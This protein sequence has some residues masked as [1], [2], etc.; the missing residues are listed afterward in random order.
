MSGNLKASS[1]LSERKTG[2]FLDY[3]LYYLFYSVQQNDLSQI[4]WSSPLYCRWTCRGFVVDSSLMLETL[5]LSPKNDPEFPKRCLARN[6]ASHSLL[7]LILRHPLSALLLPSQGFMFYMILSVCIFCVLII[8][9]AICWYFG[10][11]DIWNTGSISIENALI[12]IVSFFIKFNVKFDYSLQSLCWKYYFKASKIICFKLSFLI[13]KIYS[14]SK[15]SIRQF[16]R[17]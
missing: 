6:F 14:F 7:I 1:W 3:L 17:K 16:A 9:I 13:F 2:T 5:L 15:N 8:G 4:A 10:Q 12:P 11:F